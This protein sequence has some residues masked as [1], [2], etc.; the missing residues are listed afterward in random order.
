MLIDDMKLSFTYEALPVTPH[1][2]IVCSNQSS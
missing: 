1:T 2:L